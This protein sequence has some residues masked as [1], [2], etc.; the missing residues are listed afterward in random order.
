M[1][2]RSHLCTSNRP[3]TT[4]DLLPLAPRLQPRTPATTTRPTT[5][6]TTP[7][8]DRLEGRLGGHRPPTRISHHRC[9]LGFPADHP[10]VSRLMGFRAGHPG[11]N[12]RLDFPVD[13]QEGHHLHHHQGRLAP[14]GFPIRNGAPTT[15]RN[16]TRRRLQTQ[17]ARP[18]P[19]LQRPVGRR[20]STGQI[21]RPFTNSFPN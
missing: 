18:L 17:L 10:A 14:M 5:T 3:T 15:I 2:A 6:Q 8:P 13:H 9:P 16:R 7:L 21:R 12:H 19:D 4:R 1:F 20:F 11:D